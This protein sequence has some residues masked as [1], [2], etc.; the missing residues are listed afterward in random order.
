MIKNIKL[1]FN[2][3]NRYKSCSIFLEQGDYTKFKCPY[4]T[5]KKE[6]GGLKE[7]IKQIIKAVEANRLCSIRIENKKQEVSDK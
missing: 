6:D 2:K 7:S 1:I 4:R 5:E 3:I